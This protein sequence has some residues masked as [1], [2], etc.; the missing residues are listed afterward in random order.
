LRKEEAAATDSHDLQT[1]SANQYVFWTLQLPKGGKDR[2]RNPQIGQLVRPNRW[3][4]V[5]IGS[6]GPR[7]TGH[8]LMEWE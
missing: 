4:A 7:A 3:K 2:D 1:I 6:S 5:V 8:R